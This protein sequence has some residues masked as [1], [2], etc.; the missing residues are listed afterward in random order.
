MELYSSL[1]KLYW[2]WYVGN[3]VEENHNSPREDAGHEAF[4]G[5]RVFSN[6]FGK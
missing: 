1:T 6:Y 3:Y 4:D 2:K 5:S